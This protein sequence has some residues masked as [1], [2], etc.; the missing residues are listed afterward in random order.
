[1]PVAGAAGIDPWVVAIIALIACNGFWV[2]YQ[3]TMYLALYHGT[4]GYLFSHAQARP[5][6]VA[7]GVLTLLALCASVPLWQAMGLL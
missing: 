1:M 2:P 5:L 4:G 3:S 6:A 7:Y